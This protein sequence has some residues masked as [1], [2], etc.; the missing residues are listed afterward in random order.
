M[1]RWFPGMM[2][3]VATCRSTDK[4]CVRDFFGDPGR[5]RIFVLIQRG[6]LEYPS[7]NALLNPR[8]DGGS[9]AFELYGPFNGGMQPSI[10]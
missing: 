10:N 2:D 5:D 4:M 6:V 7:L 9:G 8:S 3:H 1:T